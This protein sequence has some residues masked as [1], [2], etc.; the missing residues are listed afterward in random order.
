M[1]DMKSSSGVPVRDRVAIT[2]R[3]DSIRSVAAGVVEAGAI[4]LLVIVTKALHA[5]GTAKGLVA[6]GVQFGLLASLWGYGQMRKSRWRTTDLAAAGYI[7]SG[8]VLTG[9]AFVDGAAAFVVGAVV[10]L[11]LWGIVTPLRTA[12]YQENYPAATRGK[13]VSRSFMLSIAATMAFG[14]GAG[15]ALSRD[16]ANYRW[17]VLAIG[18]ALFVA[19]W[20]VRQIPTDPVEPLPAGERT[21][22]R[23]W[24]LLRDDALVRSTLAS[25]MLMG[26]ANLM[27]LPLRVE[28]LSNERFGPSLSPG[29]V[30]FYTVVLPNAARL[31][32]SPL[33]GA[34][35]DRMNFF[36]LRI[37]VNVG[38]AAGIAAFFTG[39]APLGL[40]F[41]SVVLGIASAG[42]DLAWT[43]WVTKFAPAGRTTEYM[44]LHTFLTGMRGTTAPLLSYWL[45][46]GQS[47]LT[48]ALVASALIFGASFVLIPSWRTVRDQRSVA[49]IPLE[50]RS[51]PVGPSSA[52][53]G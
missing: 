12:I 46:S 17:V 13:L 25:W 48:M 37:A 22:A 2:V 1:S 44:A 30:A 31:V 4:V 23:A 36:T 42:G 24:T 39:R 40:A 8:I 11:A 18:V 34:M 6:G 27:M 26:F 5:G 15:W 29:L 16:L 53:P 21:F 38:F 3:Y 35:F 52:G 50:S 45:V 10:S 7:A 49:A 43:L 51:V 32:M 41:G 33:W 19:A 28:F 47:I 14:Q 20:A 9:A